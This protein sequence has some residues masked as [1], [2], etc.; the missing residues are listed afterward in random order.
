MSIAV[1]K[2][3]SSLF[4]DADLDFERKFL[5][6]LQEL[7]AVESKNGYHKKFHGSF[8]V[9]LRRKIIEYDGIFPEQVLITEEDVIKAYRSKR[10]KKGLDYIELRK[11]YRPFT[12]ALLKVLSSSPH[13]YLIEDKDSSHY[14][15]Q[16]GMQEVGPEKVTM[17]S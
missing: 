10:C 3:S 15:S 4:P 8:R 16:K 13:R 14:F 5:T 11:P 2:L 1:R 12:S 7:S 17:G 6:E 9:I